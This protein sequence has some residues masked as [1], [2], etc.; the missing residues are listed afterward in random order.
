MRTNQ[1]FLLAIACLGLTAEASSERATDIQ[2]ANEAIY[3]FVRS[4]R[5]SAKREER[6]LRFRKALADKAQAQPN[7]LVAGKILL[8]RGHTPA[9]LA[10]ATERHDLEVV[11]LQIKVPYD[12]EGTVQS[13]KI[14]AV[15][16]AKHEGSFEERAEKAIAAMRYQF[17]QWSEDLPSEAAE[18]HRNVATSPMLIYSFEAYGQARSMQAIA[19]SRGVATVVLQ[20]DDVS[21]KKISMHRD[22]ME[23][24]RAARK[25]ADQKNQ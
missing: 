23:R 8:A 11:D 24:S 21:G 7:Q 14:G 15:S 4:E 19:N 6:L 1:L 20:A 13:I 25:G 18:A 3:P 16:L 22:Y 5:G 12:N 10:I 2:M 17:M 9:E